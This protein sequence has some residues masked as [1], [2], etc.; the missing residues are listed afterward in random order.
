MVTAPTDAVAYYA[1]VA[2]GFHDSYRADAN[3]LERLR[4][5]NG[6]FD[7]YVAAPGRAYDLGCGS[8]ILACELARRGLDVTGI[9]GAASMLAIARESAREQGLRAT[10]R[11][12]RLPITDDAALPPADVV[13]SSSALEYLDSMAE[14]LACVRRLLNPGGLLIFSVSNRDSLS[15]RAVRLVHAITG[16][17]AYFGLLKQFK[18][19]RGLDAD[20]ERAGFASLENAYFARADRINRTLGLVLPDRYASNM[21]IVVARR[22]R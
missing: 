20:L 17:P 13:I 9:D 18:T 3:R 7:Q 22:V 15:R 5:W 10:F 21:I 8:G 19:V 4:V 1:D 12:H 16:R 11:Q 6:L 2:R 14:A